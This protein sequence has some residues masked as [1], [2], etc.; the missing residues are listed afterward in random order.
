M[1]KM[2]YKLFAVAGVLAFGAFAISP[3]WALAQG[4]GNSG[5][6]GSDNSSSN[7]A[8]SDN[9]QSLTSGS[10][11]SQGKKL[12]G[13][14]L[15]KCQN[16]EGNINRL[17]QR[18]N[19]RTQLQ[20]NLFEK[21]A[22]RVQTYYEENNLSLSNYDELVTAVEAA[23]TQAQNTFRAMEQNG[24]SFACDGED[25]HAYTNQFRN[26]FNSTVDDLQ[27]YKTAVRNLI[28]AV[29]SVATEEA[30]NE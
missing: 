3:V 4:N 15:T 22:E 21:I 6:S 8:G 19:T 16:K 12:Q 25:P 7:S 17:M 27:A 29:R 30:S 20:L 10:D 5:D 18:V 28:V 13:D 9:G 1:S 24:G 23:R 26:S 11:N 14:N 2:K